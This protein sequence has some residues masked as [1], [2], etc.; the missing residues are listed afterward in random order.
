MKHHTTL[1]FFL[2]AT[3]TAF[4]QPQLS[5]QITGQITDNTQKVVEFANVMLH[6]S[7]DS[8]LVKGVLSTER[9]SFDFERAQH[10]NGI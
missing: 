9:G 7:A 1:F 2:L 6:C 4:A 5:G 10:R 8:S 3:I